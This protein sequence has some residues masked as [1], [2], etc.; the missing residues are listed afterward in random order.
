MSKVGCLI[1]VGVLVVLAVFAGLFATGLYNG[2]VEGEERLNQQWAQVQTAYQR[3]AD[4]IP[5]LVNSVKGAA[6]FERGTLE[7]VVEA[8]S[9]VGQISPQATSEI[10]NDPQKLA[11]FEQAQN[12]LGSALSRLLVVVE[13]YPQLTAVPAFRDLMTQL[14][15]T[16]NRIATER[17][18]FNEVA[19]AWNTRVRRVPASWFISVLGWPFQTKAYFESQQGAETAPRVDFGTDLR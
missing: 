1:G 18:R 13:Q 3:R 7:S 17:R 14:E 10:L 9:R 12:Q 6:N 4:L 5:N 8:R 15:G 11:Q 16:E 2:L 19:Q